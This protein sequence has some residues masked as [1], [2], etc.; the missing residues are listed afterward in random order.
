[1]TISAVVI[2]DS[3]AMGGNRITTMQLSYHRYIHSEFMTH[4]VFS[5][6]AGSSRAIPTPK[7][8]EIV[9]NRPVLP[10]EWPKNQAGMQA[11]ELISDAAAVDAEQIWRL[12]AQAA[13]GVAQALLDI[14]VHKQ[15]ANRVLEPYLPINVVVT[16]T[17][18]SNW[19]ALRDHKDAQPEIQ[20]LARMMK[21]AMD[22]SVPV[23]MRENGW[24]LPYISEG[25]TGRA[26]DFLGSVDGAVVD[27]VLRKISAARCAR[28]SYKAFDGSIASVED[29]LNLYDKLAGSHPRHMSPLEHIA[30]AD[31]FNIAKKYWGNLHGWVQWR[32]IIEGE[33]E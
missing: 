6:N 31:P 29:D 4:R 7:L 14:G 3:L 22:A 20:A 16:A 10:V 2:A 23:P 15:V 21:A 1:M 28:V 11:K 32:R 12:G 18:W 24:H 26:V 25:D 19:F 9:R 33:V 30:Q 13:A 27:N 5:R 8:L 17:K